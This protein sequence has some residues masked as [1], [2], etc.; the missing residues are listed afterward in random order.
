MPYETFAAGTGYVA[1]YGAS[2]PR[3]AAVASA[4]I[5]SMDIGGLQTQQVSGDVQ[6]Q[7]L[8]AVAGLVKDG[9]LSF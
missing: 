4:I 5:G 9:G 1:S 6:A 8:S 2:N 3:A 7:A